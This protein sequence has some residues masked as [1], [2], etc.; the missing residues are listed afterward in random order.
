MY[1]NVSARM[2]RGAYLSLSEIIDTREYVPPEIRDRTKKSIAEYLGDVAD[3]YM[4]VW[5]P[6]KGLV[7]GL[8]DTDVER[9]VFHYHVAVPVQQYLE[10][11]RSALTYIFEDKACEREYPRAINADHK[12]TDRACK[13]SQ[14]FFLKG[15][16]GYQLIIE[17]IKIYY[18]IPWLPS[19]NCP[20]AY[21]MD[22]FLFN[23]WWNAIVNEQP[24]ESHYEDGKKV[25]LYIKPIIATSPKRDWYCVSDC[26]LLDYGHYL[27][28][29]Y[30]YTE[31]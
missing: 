15:I 31:D 27:G 4:A 25:N 28:D 8:E 30:G 19:S 16:L 1:D 18:E 13:N 21:I 5:L 11:Q 2:I 7:C 14:A 3:E 6:T 10:R 20:E 22:S 23:T 26:L 9:G 24:L 12:Y 29:G 17:M